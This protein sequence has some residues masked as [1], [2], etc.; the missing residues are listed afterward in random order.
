MVLP[1][2]FPYM[3]IFPYVSIGAGYSTS[4]FVMSSCAGVVWEYASP[5]MMRLSVRQRRV[6]KV[7]LLVLGFLVIWSA[8]DWNVWGCGA[9]AG[10]LYC[11]C[12]LVS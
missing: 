1:K 12:G 6:L 4:T 10:I 2:L 3:Y 11:G 5:D 9:L 7:C 8:N